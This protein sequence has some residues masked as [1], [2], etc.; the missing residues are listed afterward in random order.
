MT[1]LVSLTACSFNLHDRADPEDDELFAAEESPLD[2]D[3]PII[4]SEEEKAAHALLQL[5]SNDAPDHSSA[6]APT[7]KVKKGSKSFTLTD[8]LSDD[9]GDEG[10]GRGEARRGSGLPSAAKKDLSKDPRALSALLDQEVDILLYD[11]FTGYPQASG[12]LVEPGM[13][14]KVQVFP[15]W[16]YVTRHQELTLPVDKWSDGPEFLFSLPRNTDAYMF[17]LQRD[18]AMH[19]FWDPLTK[20]P[21]LPPHPLCKLQP[22]ALPPGIVP[23]PL[24]DHVRVLRPVMPA[25]DPAEGA[26]GQQDSSGDNGKGKKVIDESSNLLL[27]APPPAAVALPFKPIAAYS[28]PEG[29]EGGDQEPFFPPRANDEDRAASAVQFDEG[30]STDRPGL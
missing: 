21:K 3:L 8:M 28:P 15:A 2:L 25:F 17:W 7:T 24:G 11:T 6:L 12:L 10:G 18:Q 1:R 16:P 20:L 23:G 19:S 4:P 27:K 5:Q 29:G 26:Q 14:V 9:E 22:A 13:R 30:E